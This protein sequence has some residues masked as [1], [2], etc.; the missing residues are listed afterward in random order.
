MSVKPNILNL[1][2]I[3]VGVS[4]LFTACAHHR[5]VR[6][7]AN[8]VHRVVLPTDD[9]ERGNQEA[10][11]EA[12][13]YCESIHKQAFFIDEKANYTGSMSESDYKSAKT[14]AKVAQAVGGAGYVFGGSKEKTAGGLLG[15]GGGI[16]DG[17]LGK[18]YKVEMSFKCQ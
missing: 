5:D 16:A 9:T 7:G 18:G 4:L 2:Y 8:G 12:N 13:D 14:A 11:S 10:I 17:A 1:K 15:I 6:P 3:I